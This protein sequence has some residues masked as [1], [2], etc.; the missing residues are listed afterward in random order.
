VKRG[1]LDGTSGVKLGAAEAP[2]QLAKLLAQSSES[3]SVRLDIDRH[4]IVAGR[5]T[6]IKVNNRKHPA[7]ERVADS[8]R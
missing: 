8:F 1:V 5:S 2:R 4:M 6:W 3:V 7:M